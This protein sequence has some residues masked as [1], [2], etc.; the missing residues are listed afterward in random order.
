[1]AGNSG[2]AE[3][4]DALHQRLDRLAAE[5]AA[6]RRT[7]DALRDS[8]SLYRRLVELSPDAVYV[9]DHA[10]RIVFINQAGTALFGAAMPSQIIGSQV[11]R[12]IHP[13][14]SETTERRIR[15]VLRT[16][17]EVKHLA[18][19]RLRLDGSDFYGDVGATAIQ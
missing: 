4:I 17:A 12:F 16:G 14:Y 1:M 5:L 6:K 9:H 3:D 7:N 2:A 19:R 8:E 10:Q 15:Q 11:M 18:Q 13:E